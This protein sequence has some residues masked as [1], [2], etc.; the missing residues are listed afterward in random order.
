MGQ[1]KQAVHYYE[2]DGL[3]ERVRA[4]LAAAGLGEGTLTWR[5]LA[6]LD[7]F[8]ARGLAATKEM[9]ELLTLPPQ[10]NFLDIGSGLGGPA[11]YLAANYGCTVQGIDL[12]QSYVDIAN[13]L[14]ERTGLAERVTFECGNATALPYADESFDAAWTQHVAM[15]IEDRSTFYAEARRVLKPGGK[16][17]I[18]DVIAGA[19]GSV[20]FP[21]PWSN[22]P[23]TSF[24]LNEQ[25]MKTQLLAAGFK[26]DS[27]L[28]RTADGIAWFEDFQQK[29]KQRATPDETKTAQPLGLNTIVGPDLAERT[30]NF[31]RSLQE[32]RAGL[33]EAILVRP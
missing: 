18:Y 3:L 21:V 25:E 10:S 14:A 30:A 27:W 31:L 28:N 13:Y 17:A 8:H 33:V 29:Q 11:R 26:I 23:E 12:T 22:G 19:E 20:H 4:A 6:P 9:A 7:Q 5:D 32:G 1:V 15:N 24:L 16:L 2:K